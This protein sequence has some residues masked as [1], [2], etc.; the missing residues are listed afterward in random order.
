[1]VFITL[2]EKKVEL[3]S[4]W[5]FE[6]YGDVGYNSTKTGCKKGCIE[7]NNHLPFGVVL[8]SCSYLR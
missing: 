8:D 1:M 5:L 7:R 6:W 4:R 2:E 3:G